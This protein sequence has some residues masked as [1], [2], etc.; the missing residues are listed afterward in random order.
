MSDRRTKHH[1]DPRPD[2]TGQPAIDRPRRATVNDA[3]PVAPAKVGD[4]RGEPLRHI[5]VRGARE[6]N[7]KS[8]D[9][10]IPRDRLVVVTGLSGS[11]KSS[12]AF[13]T[14]FAEGQRRYMESLSAYARQFLDQLKKPDADEIDGLPPTIAI[15]Q[16]SATRSPRSTVATVTEIHD[17]L[18]LLFARVGQPTCPAPVTRDAHDRVI[19]RCGRAIVATD[20]ARLTEALMMLPEGARISVLA[21]IVRGNPGKHAAAVA[22][23]AK[24]GFVR[25]RI[26]GRTFDIA[27]ALATDREN[28]LGSDG[29]TAHDL[30]VI[31]DRITIRESGRA[32]IADSLET[33][34]KV[35]RGSLR[36]A[37]HLPNDDG[38]ESIEESLHSERLSCPDHP[39]HALDE[40][41]PRLFSFN[42]PHGACP[43]CHGLGVMLE[44]SEARILPDDTA[45]LMDGG[46]APFSASGPAGAFATKL[47]RAFCR[48]HR[49]DSKAVIGSLT[50]AQRR[51]LLHGEA[52]ETQAEVAPGAAADDPGLGESVE[53]P[54]RGKRGKRRETGKPA[55]WQGVIP[56]LSGWLARTESEAVREF[57]EAFM[58]ERPCPRCQ[59]DR[60]RIGALA[61]E[62]RS[63]AGLPPVVATNRRSH[64]LS[65]ANGALSIA[66]LARVSIADAATILGG[67]V[68]GEAQRT[69]ARPILRDVLARL[70]F[71]ASVGLGYLA[72][73]RRTSTLSGGEAQRIRL[74][75]QVGAG[76]VGAAYV[77]DEPTIG[78]HPRDNDRLIRT[79]RHLTDVGN[80]VIVV[81]HDEE[82]IRAADHIIDIGP[83]PGVHG[84]ELVAQGSLDDIIA[85]PASLTG[86][87]L[88]GRRS[89]ATPATTGRRP[90]SARR[91]IRVVGAR[92]HNLRD[93]E[94]IFPLG[95]FICVTGVSGSGKSTLVNDILLRQAQRLI[96]G[97]RAEPGAHDRIQGLE[98]FARVVE[99]DQGPI[100]RTPRSNAATY[101]GIFDEIRRIFS[102]CPEAR[103]R[104]YGAGRFSF[105]VKGGRCEACQGQ[106]HQRVSMHFLPDVFVVCDTC[107]GTRFARE[108]LAIRYRGLHIADV[109][110]MTVEN[111]LDFFATYP[112]IHRV[113]T[114]LSDVGLDYLTLGQPSTTLSGGEAQRIKL[115]RELG[116][117]ALPAPRRRK[118]SGDRKSRFADAAAPSTLYVLDEPTTGLHFEDV[119]RLSAVLDR[120]VDQGNTVVVIEHNLDLIKR[121]DWVIDLGPEGGAGGG[122]LVAMGTPEEVANTPASHTG[123]F[124]APLLGKTAGAQAPE[125]IDRPPTKRK[126]RKTGTAATR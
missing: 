60:L 108:T 87:Y 61:I 52:A 39:E 15:E 113:V 92:E 77:L 109:L 34:F 20:A 66:D 99:I 27:D 25:A 12:L 118:A 1:R 50:E 119:R 68:L 40:L 62:L 42:S 14:V 31:V 33:A 120:L 58:D 96:H 22:G 101:T 126:R 21:P 72:L 13:D 44:L 94:A 83:G 79:L 43:E 2:P 5:R 76:I 111:A 10:D 30:D 117:A 32:R 24:D 88:A 73:G 57:L 121:A 36:V 49:L 11:G 64:G 54:E 104:G 89:I 114:C 16:Q 71:L 4:D 90:T 37:R 29:T 48:R 75:T 45:P 105:N 65:T 123:H 51:A 107:H 23:L 74:G 38:S 93:I 116:A 80:T 81:E 56:W 55:P 122:R 19:A 84:G 26:D 106:G 8:L 17:Y 35:G 102:Q 95:G 78:L 18:R 67:L 41:E 124:L 59:G 110:S 85:T 6:H 97:G 103:V 82:M 3:P 63:Q 28:P 46:V 100:G 91:A 47:L 9:V 115:A 69:I 53:E 112:K 125:R 70:S 7:L 98:A 86:D